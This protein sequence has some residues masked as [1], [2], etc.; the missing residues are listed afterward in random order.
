MCSNPPPHTHA[1]SMPWGKIHKPHAHPHHPVTSAPFFL[2][3][4]PPQIWMSSLCICQVSARHLDQAGGGKKKKSRREGRANNVVSLTSFEWQLSAW[5]SSTLM[6]CG[7]QHLSIITP[8]RRPPP[9]AATPRN[10]TQPRVSAAGW[11]STRDTPLFRAAPLGSG[12]VIQ[13][14]AKSINNHRSLPIGPSW[15]VEKV[16]AKGR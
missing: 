13:A 3:F 1:I 15:S 4:P 2:F 5:P 9:P 11:I 16:Q 10:G 8:S 7:T 6:L 14:R 12:G